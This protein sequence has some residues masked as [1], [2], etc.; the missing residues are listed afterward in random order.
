[1]NQKKAKRI[2]K[3]LRAAGYNTVAGETREYMEVPYTRKNLV[4]F[5][6]F[7]KVM[8]DEND[9][10]VVYGYSVT[11]I[12]KPGSGRSMYRRAKSLYVTHR[13]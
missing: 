5:D 12:N 3:E 6:S 8:L 7:G 10:P 4:S 2:R 11:L 13:V 1:M 9:Q